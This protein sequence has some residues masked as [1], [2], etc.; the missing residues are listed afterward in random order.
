MRGSLNRAMKK[1]ATS[2]HTF[3]KCTDGGRRVGWLVAALPAWGR[4]ILTQLE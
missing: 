3:A 4:Q 2:L 1:Y